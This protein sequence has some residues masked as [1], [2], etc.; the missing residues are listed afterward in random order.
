MPIR[1]Q[2]LFQLT[3]QPF[4]RKYRLRV[5]IFE[6]LIEQRRVNLLLVVVRHVYIPSFFA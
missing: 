5:L 3:E 6:Q 4:G 1:R 2:G